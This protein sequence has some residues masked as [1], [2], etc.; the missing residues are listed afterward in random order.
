MI[1]KE[2]ARMGSWSRLRGHDVQ[3]HLENSNEMGYLLSHTQHQAV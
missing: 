1:G 3:D 2:V